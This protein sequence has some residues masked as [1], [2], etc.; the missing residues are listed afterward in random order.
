MFVHGPEIRQAAEALIERGVN[1]CGSAAAA[2]GSTWATATSTSSR[3][4]S[5]YRL[6]L[7]A[8]YRG[9]VDETEALLARSLPTNPVRRVLVHDGAE[10]VLDVYNRH[11][12]CL[13]PHVG[14]K[15]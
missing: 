2:P 8:R 3:A 11:L 12:T 14:L 13:F 15:S 5:V 4:A 7:D 9:I 10:V 1:D 6:V